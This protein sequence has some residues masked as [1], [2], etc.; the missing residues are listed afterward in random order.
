MNSIFIDKT[1]NKQWE[2]LEGNYTKASEECEPV[3]EKEKVMKKQ[4]TKLENAI[5]VGEATARL[6][7]NKRSD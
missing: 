2:F 4:V 7:I 3:F 1:R 5:F 6:D